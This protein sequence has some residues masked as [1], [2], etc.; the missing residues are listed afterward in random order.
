MQGRRLLRF[1]WNAANDGSSVA[2]TYKSGLLMAHGLKTALQQERQKYASHPVLPDMVPDHVNAQGWCYVV[3][4]YFLTEMAFKALLQV[5]EKSPPPTH[6]LAKLFGQ[7]DKEDQEVLREYYSDFQATIGGRVGA[8]PISSLDDFLVNLDGGRGD[9]GKHVGSFEWRYCLIEEAGSAQ[10]PFVSVDYLHEVVYGCVKM[11]VYE[12]NSLFPPRR[13]THSY[14]LRWDRRRA[15]GG[16]LE[17]QMLSDRWGAVGESWIVL[18]GPDYRGRF[19]LVRHDEGGY[20]EYFRDWPE[21]LEA[22]VHDMRG[23]V[24]RVLADNAGPGAGSA[25]APAQPA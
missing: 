19:D 22:A 16:W 10:M 9:H 8:F 6:S 17:T 18:W 7:L 23:E 25:D 13:Y 24:M 3:A 4:G 11:I 5:K 21:D 1:H 15:Y 14:R 2:R 12:E 20:R